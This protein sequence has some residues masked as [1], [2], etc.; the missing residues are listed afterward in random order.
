MSALSWTLPLPPPN[1]ADDAQVVER[2]H[3]PSST[4]FPN[5]TT[6]QRPTT[7]LCPASATNVDDRQWPPP[8]TM[9]T[10]IGRR[11]G[12]GSSMPPLSSRSSSRPREAGSSVVVQ[13]RYCSTTLAW[14]MVAVMVGAVVHTVVK[15]ALL[16]PPFFFF[17]F[18]CFLHVFFLFFSHLYTR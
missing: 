15:V 10:K 8:T 2:P 17:F 12:T 9:S 14:A 16:L 5:P 4:P 1:H 3:S 11:M 7:P 6:Q 13:P 18:P